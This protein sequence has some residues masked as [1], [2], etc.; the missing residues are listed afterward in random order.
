MTLHKFV[1]IVVAVILFSMFIL[2]LYYQTRGGRPSSSPSP[3]PSPSPPSITSYIKSMYNDMSYND[4]GIPN[5]GI[6]VSM[7][8][9][10]ILCPNYQWQ[11]KKC[12]KDISQCG[13]MLDISDINSVQTRVRDTFS[14]NCYSIDTSYLRADMPNYVFGPYEG[15]DMTIGIIIDIHKI[16]DYIACM[17]PIDSASISRYNCTCKEQNN[18][19]KSNC[20]TKYGSCTP[21]IKP[22]QWIGKGADGWNKYLQTDSSK[23]IAMAGCG[24]IG[25][26]PT[27]GLTGPASDWI[28]HTD[29]DARS[30]I[31][32]K[33]TQQDIL[34][35]WVFTD[36]NKPFSKYQWKSWVAMAKKIYQLADTYKFTELQNKGFDGYRENEVDIIVPNKNRDPTDPCMVTDEFKK[37]WMDSILGVFTNAKTNCSN[38]EN[39]ATDPTYG[40]NS[41]D[42]CCGVDIS[43]QIV[44]KIVSDFNK[45]LPPGR[46]PIHGY[47]LD[48]INI[49]KFGWNRNTL[50][51]LD[52]HKLPTM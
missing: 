13:A 5:G 32:K 23:D 40:C 6:L 25:F 8:D 1:Y 24:K 7:L 43:V 15:G 52:L 38:V 36:K 3:S 22:E 29:D 31:N 17:F 28:V 2:L 26:A 18:C 51:T 48:T 39:I 37:V 20:T 14:T 49:L 41:P 12:L 44:Q 45:K 34:T 21:D 42:C 9:T 4:D 11:S 16:W 27:C 19:S 33:V 35:N 30:H 50:G 46:E 47:K 10:T